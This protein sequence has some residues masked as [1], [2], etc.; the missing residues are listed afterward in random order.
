MAS[1]A[2]DH[3]QCIS[4]ALGSAERV[5]AQRGA[6]LTPLRKRVLELIWESH[7][8]MKAYDLLDRLGQEGGSAKPPTVYRALDFL[9]AQG[10]VHRIESENAYVGCR[11]PERTHEFQLLICDDCRHV[12]EIAVS[13]VT[14]A[15]GKHAKKQGFTVTS[16][17]VEVHGQCPSCRDRA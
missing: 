4:E 1:H 6:R 2:H 3:E 9:L 5:C 15:L 13:G 10:L 14:E 8:A 11:H 12:E 7:E 16:Q 17:T